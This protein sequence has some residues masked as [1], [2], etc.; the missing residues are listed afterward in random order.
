MFGHL[1]TVSHCYILGQSPIF[2]ALCMAYIPYP[3]RRAATAGV[4]HLSVGIALVQHALQL[5]VE[6]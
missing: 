2:D 6:L 1:P 3:E 5:L 4:V